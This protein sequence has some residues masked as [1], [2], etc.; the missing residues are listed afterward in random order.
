MTMDAQLAQLLQLTLNGV[1]IGAIYALVAL[2]LVLTYKAT[3]VLNF[4]HG[5]LVMFSAFLA[6][7]LIV[8]LQ[9]PFWIA[10]A[11]VVAAVGLLA[12]ILE[13]GLMRRI[14]GQP[15]H[16]GVMLT[17]AIAFIM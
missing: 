10:A 15:Q 11:L 5:D 12:Y 6:W 2:G 8:P 3:E 14:S 7:W 4:A 1:A 17:I 9:V 16:A 13:A